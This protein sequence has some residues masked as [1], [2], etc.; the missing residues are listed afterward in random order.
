MPNMSYFQIVAKV[1]EVNESSYTS[2]ATGEVQNKVQ[3]SLVVPGMRDR[4]LCEMPQAD[5]PKPDT[6]DKW[7]LEESWIVVSAEGMRALAFER[8][9][10]RAGEKS[11]GSLVVFQASAVREA[12]SD[13]RRELQQARKAQK[14]K[15]KQARAARQAEKQ[16]KKEAEQAEQAAKQSA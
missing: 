10:A 14:V 1:E 9:N 6:L 13:E 12:S 7:E 16:A 11:V 5:A 8:S 2:Q 4:V 15:A 3:F